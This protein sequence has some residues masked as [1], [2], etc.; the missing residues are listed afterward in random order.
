MSS[1]AATSDSPPS[2][3]LVS[4]MPSTSEPAMHTMMISRFAAHRRMLA[5]TAFAGSLALVACDDTVHV[6]T[7]APLLQSSN[8]D[9][10]AGSWKMIVLTG[11]D[12]IA[13]AAPAASTSD[14]FRAEVDAVKSAQSRM[15]DA[16]QRAVAYWS[17]GG[18][19]RWNQ[20][21]RELVARYNLPPAPRPDGTYAVPDAENPF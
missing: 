19:I 9:A 3:H 13:V 5:A 15:T 8:I 16:Q 14:A 4:R 17:S 21:E 10:S 6:T 20:I 2:S 1:R 18:V 7:E 12:Q 11:P